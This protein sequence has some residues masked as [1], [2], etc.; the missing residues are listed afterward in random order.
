VTVERAATGDRALA[1]NVERGERVELTGIG[2]A[3]D[4]AVLL[5][6]AGIGG[7]RF[8]AAEFERPAT[9]LVEVRQDGRGFD[10]LGRE[11]ERRKR[12]HRTW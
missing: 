9:I 2:D 6:D 4:H 7:C 3:G 11:A 5:L 1:A 10:R 12:A 8:H